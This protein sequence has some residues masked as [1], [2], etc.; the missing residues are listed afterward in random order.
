MSLARTYAHTSDP[1]CACAS[2]FAKGMAKTKYTHVLLELLY[3]TMRLI[4]NT[5]LLIKLHKNAL[6][7]TRFVAFDKFQSR[8]LCNLPLGAGMGL[9]KCLARLLLQ[10]R[11]RGSANGAHGNKKERLSAAESLSKNQGVVIRTSP[12]PLTV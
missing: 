1:K 8:K 11:V 10:T 3:I 2:F 6:F 4:V 5:F 12:S 9:K 7:L